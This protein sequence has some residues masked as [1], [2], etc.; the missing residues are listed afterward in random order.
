M[1]FEGDGQVIVDIGTSRLICRGD[2]EE[3]LLQQARIS[4]WMAILS[5]MRAM[6][7]VPAVKAALTLRLGGGDGWGEGLWG[8]MC[9]AP[10][11]TPDLRGADSHEPV[12][13]WIRENFPTD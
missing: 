10:L 9:R 5:K 13:E 11:E 2:G 8:P 1:C 4:G 12:R 7:E 6:G 3:A